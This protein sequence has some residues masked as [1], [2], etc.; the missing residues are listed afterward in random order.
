L[1]EI[2]ILKLGGSVITVKDKPMTANHENIK[3]LCEEIKAAS[4]QSLVIV[5]GGGS[6]GHPV[7]R[8]YGIADG[9]TSKGQVPGFARTH[10]AMVTLNSIIVDALWDSGVPAL[11]VTPSSFIITD[12]GRLNTTD[13]EIV[14]RLVDKGILPVLYGDAVLD[15]TKGFSILSGDQ[16]AVRLALEMNASRLV[17]GVDVDGVYTSNPKLSTEARLIEHLPLKEFD[18]FTEIG[19]ALTTDVTGGMLGKVL[20]ARVAVEAGVEVQVVNASKR[21]MIF[22]ALIGEPVAGT[23]LTR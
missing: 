2:L 8:K 17:F 6:F 12:D 7:A 21:D 22:K 4:P 10:Q 23:V 16:L 5:H 11:S 18:D 19:R 13:F 14:R 3:R 9:F 15:R 20:E 1:T